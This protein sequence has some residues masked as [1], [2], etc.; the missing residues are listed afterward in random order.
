LEA[1]TQINLDDLVSSFGWEKRPL[2]AATLRRMFVDAARKFARQMLEFD[3]DV[4][5]LKLC[6]AS[7]QFTQRRYIRE[8]RVHGSERIPSHGP[9][10]FVSN[11]P[12]MTDTICLFAAIERPDLRIL[13]ARRPFL[14]SLRNTAQHCIFVSDAPST[15][16]QAGGAAGRDSSAPRGLCAQLPG[17]GDRT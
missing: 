2:M 10:L 7:R 17:W 14:V 4:G 12:G 13:A 1:L 5:E 9:V 8:L 11:H 16:R 15:R 3:H 6:E